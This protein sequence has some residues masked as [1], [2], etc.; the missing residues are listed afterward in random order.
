LRSRALMTALMKCTVREGLGFF[1]R[2]QPNVVLNRSLRGW[3]V[4]V[5]KDLAG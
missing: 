4:E 3:S 2:S 5:T 1:L